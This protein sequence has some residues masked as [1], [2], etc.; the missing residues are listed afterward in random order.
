MT[1][2]AESREMAEAAP[3]G[4]W[5]F[6]QY[7]LNFPHIVV[8]LIFDHYIL[9]P[10]E[11]SRSLEAHGMTTRQTF[12]RE[13]GRLRRQPDVSVALRGRDPR[14]RRAFNRG[15]SVRD[16][17][18]RV[19]RVPNWARIASRAGERLRAGGGLRLEG[20]ER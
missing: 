10:S 7:P 5:N 18:A 13:F 9:T 20:M 3:C 2:L 12:P 14:Y 17:G 6:P 11:D 16:H 4:D 8:L 1:P 19:F 15:A